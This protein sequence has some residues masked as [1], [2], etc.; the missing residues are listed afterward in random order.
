MGKFEIIC[1]KIKNLEIQG[2]ENIA[3]AGLKAYA[4][5][6]NKNSIK[7]LLSLRYTEPC[8]ANALKFAEKNSVKEALEYLERS[9]KLIAKLGANLVKGNVYTHCHSSSVNKVLVEAKNKRNFKVYCTETRPRFQ[10]RITAVELAKLKIPV[11]MYVDSAMRLAIKK[12][13][14]AMIGADSITKKGEV[15]NK[16]GS[17]LVADTCNHFK[18]PLYIITNSWKFDMRSLY[19]KEIPIE[20]RPVNEV[21][22]KVPRGVSIAN[23]A[24]EKIKPSSIKAIVS[25]L[26]ILSP[27]SFV[28]KVLKR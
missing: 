10:G 11:E 22:D 25:E 15:I 4:L 6:P 1:K 12:A 8:L 3:K 18:V 24:F 2:A 16:I 19:K 27:K 23:P 21:W 17:E 7:K 5:K 26:G 20:K 13:K 28:K 9:D 14:V